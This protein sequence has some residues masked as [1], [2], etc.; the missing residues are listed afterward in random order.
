MAYIRTLRAR[1]DADVR[2]YATSMAGLSVHVFFMCCFYFLI[3]LYTLCRILRHVPGDLDLIF[4]RLSCAVRFDLHEWTRILAT[5][6]AVVAHLVAQSVVCVNKLADRGKKNLLRKTF[7]MLRY[8]IL[9]DGYE[10]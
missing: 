3:L 6:C 9:R 1:A 8:L 4:S 5:K 10:G 2:I 7:P